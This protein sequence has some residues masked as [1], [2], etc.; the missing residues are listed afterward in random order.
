IVNN[1][2]KFIVRT[3]NS[4]NT[5]TLDT[6]GSGLLR[7]SGS[8]GGVGF[9]SAAVGS[10]TAQVTLDLATNDDNSEQDSVSASAAAFLEVPTTNF[11]TRTGPN[12][13]GKTITLNAQ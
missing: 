1:S 10:T 12:K 9:E 4:G 7:V 3:P 2:A 13:P 11:K 8:S 6:P 5:L